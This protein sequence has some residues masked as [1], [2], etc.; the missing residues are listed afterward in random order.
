MNEDRKT[1]IKGLVYKFTDPKFA[2][3]N[4]KQVWAADYIKG[5]SDGQIFLLYGRPGVGKSFVSI[6][7]A[8]LRIPLYAHL[9]VLIPRKPDGRSV[10]IRLLLHQTTS[11]RSILTPNRMHCGV[12][13]RPLLALTCGDTGTDDDSIEKKLQVWLK[14]GRR[15]GAVMLI[16]EADV[17]LEKRMEADLKRKGREIRN[18]Q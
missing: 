5:K 18:G 12:T 4:K 6:T 7:Q 1:M 10:L 15:W 8:R 11:Q 13:G 14:L 9:Q 2:S 16:D 17:F 3:A